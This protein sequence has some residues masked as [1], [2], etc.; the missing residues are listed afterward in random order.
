MENGK[1]YVFA[2]GEYLPRQ[3]H[4]SI[5]DAAIGAK[6]IS[7]QTQKTTNVM[8]YVNSVEPVSKKDLIPCKMCGKPVYLTYACSPK[9]MAAVCCMRCFITVNADTEELV[10]QKWNKLMGGK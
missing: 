3:E 4:W 2:E 10:I 7:E 6:R 9:K 8:V 1:F 5:V